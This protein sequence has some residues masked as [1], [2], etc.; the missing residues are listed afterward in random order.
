MQTKKISRVLSWVFVA[1]AL[2]FF[3]FPLVWT[4]MTALKQRTDIF[5]Y[6]PKF[7]FKTTFDNFVTAMKE[8]DI[9]N[10][11]R[12]SLIVSIVVTSVSLVLGASA[13][14]VLA[15]YKSK[16]TSWVN[17]FILFA[18]TLPAI[19][20]TFPM[21]ILMQR[22]NLRDTQVS[23]I[24]AHLT[25]GIPLAIWL[26]SG[27]F[28]QAPKLEEAATVD[29]CSRIM[30]F[31]RIIIPSVQSGLA[32][33]AILVF[34]ESWNDLLYALIL[35]NRAAKTLPVYI[36]SFVTP[37]GVS[38]GP[39]FATAVIIMIPSTIFVMVAGKKLVYGLTMGAM[40]E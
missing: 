32:A 40:K 2:V 37:V 35:T 26:S 6:P 15:R 5:A 21:F 19:I 1:A 27:F 13:G 11:V 10:G 14:Y 8:Q 18:R 24:I 36:M 3:L 16:T 9:L 29:G 20:M 23:V 38:W 39:M 31:F 17:I 7:I 30:A 12:N 28:E 34:L 22:L 33:T 4:V 25:V